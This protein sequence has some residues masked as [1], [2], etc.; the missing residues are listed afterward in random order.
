LAL[1]FKQAFPESFEEYQFEEYQGACQDGEVKPGQMF[2]VPTG[3][4]THARY[5]INFP[6]KRHWKNPFFR[7]SPALAPC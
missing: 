7:R 6:T 2:I 5:I 3:Y 1:Q 4:L